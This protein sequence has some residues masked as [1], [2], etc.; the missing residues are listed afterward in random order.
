MWG[1]GTRMDLTK[2][3]STED[4]KNSESVCGKLVN[5]FFEV[6]FKNGLV[7]EEYESFLIIVSTVKV[8][9]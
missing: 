7:N 2:K 6:L 8:I 9:S 4:V 5:Q 1:R 3:I